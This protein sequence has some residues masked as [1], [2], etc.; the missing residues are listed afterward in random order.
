M[1]SILV[2]DPSE[3]N[4]LFLKLLLESHDYHVIESNSGEQGAKF[5]EEYSPD[6]IIAEQNLPFMS[7]LD[8]VT[9]IKQHEAKTDR[10]TPIFIVTASDDIRATEK[11]LAAGAND[12]LQKPYLESLLIAKLASLFHTIDI[13]EALRASKKSVAELNKELEMEQYAAEKIFDKFVNGP[14]AKVV[15]VN[16]KLSSASIFNGDVFLSAIA[17]S[18]N[19]F[20]LLGD[21]TGHGLPAAIGAIPVAE[22]FYSMVQK[23]LSL[24]MI[25]KVI[26]D[27]LKAFLP[28]HIFF[29]C[30]AVEVSPNRKS[31]RILNAGMQPALVLNPKTREVTEF[32][33]S[34]VPL[35]VLASANLNTDFQMMSV[36]GSEFVVFYSDGVVEAKNDQDEMFGVERV[37][38]TLLNHSVDL[39]YL[40]QTSKA[41]AAGEAFDDDVSLIC[42]DVKKVLLAPE[43]ANA[44]GLER[45]AIPVD[46][47]SW[48]KHFCFDSIS[49]KSSDRIVETIVESI[50]LTLPII[51][52]KEALFIIVAELMSNMVEHGILK[53]DSKLKQEKNGH[54]KYLQKKQ[55]GLESLTDIKLSILVEHEPVISDL[56]TVAGRLRFMMAY[57]TEACRFDE[58]LDKDMGETFIIDESLND[59][60]KYY[61]RGN[62]LL[63]N[64]CSK[65]IYYR[66][67]EM[68]EAVFEWYGE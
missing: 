1:P 47:G 33:S 61:G 44:D 8:F 43:Q 56:K 62:I 42:I 41:F 20:T 35:G 49:L 45:V 32:S 5:F 27:K 10:F 58:H 25:V 50:M 19:L 36:D 23:G 63:N 38:E 15:G 51:K 57:G 28:V 64:L 66:S 22:S 26:N 34:I 46:V 9:R 21:F 17:P 31:L 60:S 11:M 40:F 6:L 13:Y 48:K 59:F 52:H 18:G 37:K 7:G 16:A 12:F 68:V 30:I 3:S 54:S 24:Q 29:G 55:L 53:L 2:V 14:V 4:R 67:G 65:L 39:E